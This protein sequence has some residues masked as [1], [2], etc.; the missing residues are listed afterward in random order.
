M[1]PTY[2]SP[3]HVPSPFTTRLATPADVDALTDLF[4]HSCNAPFWQYA[5]PDNP[6]N[7]TWWADVWRLGIEKDPTT[8]SFIAFDASKKTTELSEGT[9]AAFARWVIPQKDGSCERLWP[10]LPEDDWDMDVM[11]AFFGGTD[12]FCANLLSRT[13]RLTS[14]LR[15]D[16]EE[17][18]RYDGNPSA[19]E[20]VP[21]PPK[22]LNPRN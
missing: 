17:S 22:P 10:K 2:T 12:L 15:R 11:G 5:M 4:F 13:R 1:T 6:V 7:R 9:P 16:G 21:S 18:K 14:A 20:L 19:L 3:P 8:R